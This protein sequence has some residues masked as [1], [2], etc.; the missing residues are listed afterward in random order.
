MN[1]THTLPVKQHRERPLRMIGVLALKDIVTGIK[2]KNTL[3][4]VIVV[5]LMMLFYRYSWQMISSDM[6]L[7]LFDEGD[8]GYVGEMETSAMINV[9]TT[10]RA[11]IWENLIA[12]G[13]EPEL[14]LI[15]PADF[16]AQVAAGGPV[17]LEA[18]VTYWL[19]DEQIQTLVQEAETELTFITGVPVTVAVRDQRVF[20]VKAQQIMPFTTVMAFIFALL[21]V[22]I[23]LIPHLMLEEKQ[24]KTLEALLVSPASPTIIALGKGLAGLFYSL[25]AVVI[26]LLLF[27]PFIIN[28]GMAI[29]GLLLGSLFVVGLGLLVGGLIDDRQQLM[30]L[31]WGLIVPLLIPVF[32]SMM[33]D[34]LP[35]G[36]LTFMHWIP[37]VS[38][39]YIIQ[40][41]CTIDAT[42]ADV[43]GELLWL[44]G[45][46]VALFATVAWSVRR[47]D[48]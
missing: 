14:G 38:L 12:E 18:A 33:T 11:D 40:M 42:L 31:A 20:P 22:A 9:Y 35:Q 8:S 41:A 44:A 5:L 39:A 34:L 43:A 3:T 6:N 15:L 17:T 28:W 1:S 21:M 27:A 45:W 7:F 25:L 37:S 48:R 2:N 36:L 26:G 30:L 13:S 16:D 29:L 32:L 24:A 4:L 46:A 19:N 10:D 47:S 23:S